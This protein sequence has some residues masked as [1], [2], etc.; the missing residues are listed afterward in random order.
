[1]RSLFRFAAFAVLLSFLSMP[2]HAY[3]G[4]VFDA[5]SRWAGVAEPE[6]T[7]MSFRCH[8]DPSFRRSHVELYSDAGA[9]A[10]GSG[11]R[12]TSVFV[13]DG[14][15]FRVPVHFPQFSEMNADWPMSGS[16]AMTDPVLEALMA[17]NH[18]E[19]HG[20]DR[21]AGFSLRGSRAA[22][23]ALLAACARG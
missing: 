17:G 13:I 10:Q 2:A 14:R 9:R 11:V 16:V 21:A 4:W 20:G 18:A 6:Y 22:I 8:S 3:E 7:L 5:N 1:M 23:S 12:V 15:Q 19:V